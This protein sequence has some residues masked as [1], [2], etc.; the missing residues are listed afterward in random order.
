ME[1]TIYQRGDLL[2]SPGSHLEP[3][4]ADWLSIIPVGPE[5]APSYLNLNLG[6]PMGFEPAE[7]VHPVYCACHDQLHLVV[8]EVGIPLVPLHILGSVPQR[9]GLR[10]PIRRATAMILLARTGDEESHLL[11]DPGQCA[12]F[13]GTRWTVGDAGD[14][15]LLRDVGE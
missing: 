7:F 6:R 11:Y 9:K 5:A 10:G 2:C 1:F 12:V 15:L 13:V 3:Q 8:R 14:R 4:F